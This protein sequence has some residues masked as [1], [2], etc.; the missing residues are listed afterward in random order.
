[1]GAAAARVSRSAGLAKRGEAML[2]GVAARKIPDPGPGLSEV[3]AAYRVE[4]AKLAKD[5]QAMPE[6]F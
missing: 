4:H 5:L 6:T 3:R 2:I 1:M